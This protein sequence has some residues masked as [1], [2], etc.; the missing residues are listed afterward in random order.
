MPA[1]LLTN[2]RVLDVAAGSLSEPLDLLL[3]HGTVVRT[4]PSGRASG[5]NTLATPIDLAGRIVLPG[6]WDHHVHHGQLARCSQWIDVSGA[7]SLAGVV[8]TIELAGPDPERI[9]IGFHPGLW[10]TMP[11]NEL[12]HLPWPV[13]ILSA[14]LHSVWV[15]RAASRLYRGVDRSG[16]FGED[17]AFAITRQI[18]Q[19]PDG[20][21]DGWAQQVSANAAA[22]GI[23]G[24][25]DLEMADNPATWIRRDRDA[26]VLHRVRAAVYTEQFE[27]DEHL[28]P[29]GT[30]L[31]EHVTMGPLKII[32]D[33]ALGSMS[34][35]CR[36]HYAGSTGVGA[37]N[38]APDR[39]TDLAGQA[40]ARGLD[41]AVHAIGDA[42][43]GIVLDAVERT[44]ARVSIEHAQLAL[45]QDI[46]RMARP[47]VVASVQPA[48][49]LDDI[50]ALERLWPD[51]LDHAFPLAS[52]QRAG[53]RMQF[54]S[55][56]PVTP[57]NPWLAIQAAVARTDGRHQPWHTQQTLTVSQALLAS[58][59][60]VRVVRPGMSADLCVIEANPFEVAPEALGTISSALTLVGG[61]VTHTRI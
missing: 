29:T 16:L 23:T 59:N 49:L 11:T 13:A 35:W 26:T 46:A 37:P 58:T 27:H 6:L 18:Q 33:G 21:L 50:P 8:A 2:A 10:A 7:D 19:V 20:V 34:A 54:G 56:A 60:Q 41:L 43:L 1:T 4:W 9:G 40:R 31:S 55:D 28:P 15:N 42:A 24:I 14:D 52:M 5:P 3:E 36:H 39:L 61:R 57:L 53:V 22:L 32:A 44:G 48:H 51:R 47:D 38:I 45:P 17:A 25:V 12:D 30:A